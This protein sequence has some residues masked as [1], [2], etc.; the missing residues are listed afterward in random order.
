MRPQQL[1][2]WRRM[3]WFRPPS[4]KSFHTALSSP[5][6][7]ACTAS[8]IAPGE[9]VFLKRFPWGD[10]VF[11][12]LHTVSGKFRFIFFHPTYVHLLE[13]TLGPIEIIYGG[14]SQVHAY[15]CVFKSFL[16]VKQQI[17]WAQSEV[18]SVFRLFISHGCVS[19]ETE[20]IPIK[21]SSLIDLKSQVCRD[22]CY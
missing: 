21:I 8:W 2:T 3:T 20:I 18:Y 11:I 5:S 15:T 17:I 9:R 16:Q 6:P 19:G 7:T 13:P 22:L 12:W 10:S 14:W 4:A 1:L